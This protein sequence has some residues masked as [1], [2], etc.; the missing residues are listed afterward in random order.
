MDYLKI[1]TTS[2]LLRVRL[3]DVVCIKADGNY[4]Q[5]SLASGWTHTLTFQLHVIADV[6]E[7]NALTDF[8][9]V[10]RSLIVNQ[11]YVSLVNV[12]E[13][14]LVLQG[15]GMSEVMRLNASREALVELK[16]KM[17]GAQYGA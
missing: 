8:I 17:E 9:R 14:R 1:P 10:G 7:Q 5:L 3:N 13:R 15:G 2:E 12:T 6:F 11:R 4:S 16:R